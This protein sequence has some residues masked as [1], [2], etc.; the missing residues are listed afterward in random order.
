M[1][2]CKLVDEQNSIHEHACL[3]PFFFCEP[4]GSF[5]VCSLAA[6][7]LDRWLAFLADFFALRAFFF[8]FFFLLSEEEEDD[9]EEDDAVDSL[10][11]VGAAGRGSPSKP[12]RAS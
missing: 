1:L 3:H 10:S 5:D 12:G 8:F 2:N 4:S 9:E 7:R 6:R 11:G